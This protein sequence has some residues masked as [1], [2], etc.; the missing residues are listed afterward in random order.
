MINEGRLEGSS[1]LLQYPWSS[2]GIDLCLVRIN[3][4]REQQ[5]HAR[6]LQLLAKCEVPRNWD[7]KKLTP[8][9][10][11]EMEIEVI[12]RRVIPHGN[13]VKRLEKSYNLLGKYQ[14]MNAYSA[15]L[16]EEISNESLERAQKTHESNLVKLK[17]LE[18]SARWNERELEPILIREVEIE[19][20]VK[21]TP[22]PENP[23]ERVERT[24][25]LLQKYKSLN[26]YT[27]AVLER[28]KEES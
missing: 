12:F 3:L 25:M 23:A 21:N 4:S 14:E 17:T 22:L 13:A 16:L 10:E 28:L 7:E 20:L 5:I 24:F 11:G 1:G 26:T 18:Q 6:N 2:R 27:A 9:T 15:T 19:K 8:I